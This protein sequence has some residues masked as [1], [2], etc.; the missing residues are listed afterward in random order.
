MTVERQNEKA[1]DI[2]SYVKGCRN[3]RLFTYNVTLCLLSKADYFIIDVS[4]SRLKY[5]R[6]QLK[7]QQEVVFSHVMAM[8]K[9]T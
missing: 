7:L 3:A 6:S 2:L 4:F 8:I 9:V 1:N 5:S